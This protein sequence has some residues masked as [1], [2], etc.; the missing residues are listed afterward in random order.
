[1]CRPNAR[2]RRGFTLVE[3]LVVI[4][5]IGILIGL[6][7][8]AVQKARESAARTKCQSNM[9]Q[10]GLATIQAFDTYR[11]LPPA[12]GNYA[13]AGPA[14]VFYHL[15]PFVEELAIYNAG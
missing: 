15:L 13:G 6:I 5:I 8:P 10:C 1:M 3:M 9:R 2:K 7:L 4:A 11:K 14:T 12:I